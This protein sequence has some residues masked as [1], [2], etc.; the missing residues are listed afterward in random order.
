MSASKKEKY[1]S[2]FLYRIVKQNIKRLNIKNL[3]SY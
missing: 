1:N 3:L 2:I